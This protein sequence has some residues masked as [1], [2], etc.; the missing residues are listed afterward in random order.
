MLE[1]WIRPCVT[2]PKH[3]INLWRRESLQQENGRS[4]VCSEKKNIFNP[5][6][7]KT[8]RIPKGKIIY[9]LSY[10]HAKH[11]QC[12]MLLLGGIVLQGNT[13]HFQSESKHHIFYTNRS[14]RLTLSFRLSGTCQIIWA[15][16]ISY[17]FFFTVHKNEICWS[18]WKTAVSPNQ[19]QFNCVQRQIKSILL[20]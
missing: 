9:A 20:M 5:N 14:Y 4:F 10:Y 1:N 17:F 11:S 19:E 2:T 7:Q 8:S 13:W 12:F 6:T 18:I 3:E 16:P 15:L